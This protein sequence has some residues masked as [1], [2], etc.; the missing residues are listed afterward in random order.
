MSTWLGKAADLILSNKGTR[1]PI[2]IFCIAAG[3]SLASMMFLTAAD[4]TLRYVFNRP[5]FGAYDITQS[6]MVVFVSGGLAYCAIKKGHVAV[7]LVVS[8]LP[9][10]AQVIIDSIT[11]LLSIGIFSLIA[12]K[13]FELM[14]F[15]FGLKITSVVLL[16]P[17]F[18]FVGVV[19]L[20]AILLII[21][22]LAE[23]LNSLSKAVSK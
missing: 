15:M 14:Q 20:G 8:R 17:V 18:P 12:W 4:V 9:Q 22:L 13:T 10:R 1:L 3:V 23:L 19:G 2:N 7:D 11:G 21:A 16:I 5:I 6:L